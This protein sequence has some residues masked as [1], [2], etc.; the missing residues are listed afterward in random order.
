MT[1]A[2]NSSRTNV[3][4]E[5]R[6]YEYQPSLFSSGAWRSGAGFPDFRHI[7]ADEKAGEKRQGQEDHLGNADFPE[8]EFII[9][10]PWIQDEDDDYQDQENGDQDDFLGHD[11]LLLF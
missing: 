4:Q 11:N 1:N 8:I 5:H 9:D 7:E 6:A 2:S 3:R 10:F